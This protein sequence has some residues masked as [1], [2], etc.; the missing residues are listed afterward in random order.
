[1]CE[2]WNVR[3]FW[4]L[5]GI[6]SGTTNLTEAL[7]FAITPSSICYCSVM[8]SSKTPDKVSDASEKK[9]RGVRAEA[10]GVRASRL[11]LLGAAS[12]LRRS[13]PLALRVA[14]YVS[15]SRAPRLPDSGAA[16]GPGDAGGGRGY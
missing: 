4:C 2:G 6:Y 3:K 10:R 12:R 7:L 5:M 14:S 11:L 16:P 8:Y 13:H 1:M 15:R 9:K